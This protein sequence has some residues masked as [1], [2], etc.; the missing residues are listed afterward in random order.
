MDDP[1]GLEIKEE[2]EDYYNSEIN[3]GQLYPNLTELSGMGLIEKGKRDRRTNYYRLDGR[4]KSELRR[5][6]KWE[7]EKAKAVL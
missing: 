3:H 7:K 6:H 2:L 1:K 5:R 4:G